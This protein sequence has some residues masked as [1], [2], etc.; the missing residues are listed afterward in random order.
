MAR[1]K[2]SPAQI[3][4]VSHTLSVA[5]PASEQGFTAFTASVPVRSTSQGRWPLASAEEPL[6]PSAAHHFL[7]WTTATRPIVSVVF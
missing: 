3:V 6:A 1:K 2:R 4:R 5:R 7:R